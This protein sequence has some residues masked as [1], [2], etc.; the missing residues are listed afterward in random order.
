MRKRIFVG[1]PGLADSPS[2]P[3]ADLMVLFAAADYACAKNR[4][5]FERYVIAKLAGHGVRRRH[6]RSGPCSACSR[7]G[8]TSFVAQRG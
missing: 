4:V 2:A 3:S 8:Q 5:I 1:P 6:S 7:V